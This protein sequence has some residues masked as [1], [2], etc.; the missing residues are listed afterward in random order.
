MPFDDDFGL[1]RSSSSLISNISRIIQVKH[2][3]RKI[4]VTEHSTRTD[5]SNNTYGNIRLFD[6]SSHLTLIYVTFDVL[7]NSCISN[8][9]N[10][11]PIHTTLAECLSID[12]HSYC[13]FSRLKNKQTKK[14]PIDNVRTFIAYA[15]MIHLVID[16]RTS[17]MH[18]FDWSRFSRQ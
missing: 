1:N 5:V 11:I 12:I 7:V 9:D 13:V 17:I 6:V 18:A 16:D 10:R 3:T 14:P 2:R 4:T 15:P 8:L